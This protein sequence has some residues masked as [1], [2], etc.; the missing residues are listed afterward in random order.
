[1]FHPYST[2]R[3]RRP[4]LF[5]AIDVVDLAEVVAEVEAAVPRR[6][7]RAAISTRF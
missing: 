3:E 2:T 1:L 4:P 5:L 6:T 7:E